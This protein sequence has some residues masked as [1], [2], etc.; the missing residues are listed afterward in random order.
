MGW[1]RNL[2]GRSRERASTY[3]SID[4]SQKKWE[5]ILQETQAS[6]GVVDMRPESERNAERQAQSHLSP[7]DEE[8]AR[9]MVSLIQQCKSLDDAAHEEMKQIGTH[10]CENGG[11]DRMV[12]I[13]YRVKALGRR[14]RDC[15]LYWDGICGWMY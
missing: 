14:V 5:N 15:E 12:L 1:L 3:D 7:E 8:I 11:Y 13:A 9:R 10:L 4:N 6:S 2:F